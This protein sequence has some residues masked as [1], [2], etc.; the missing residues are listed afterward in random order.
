MDD[1][2]MSKRWK[3]IDD[4]RQ[5]SI[6]DLIRQS[7]GKKLNVAGSMQ[8][9][10]ELQRAIDNAIRRSPLSRHQ[11]AGEMSHLL[12]EE[13]SKAMIDSWTA[14]SKSDRHIPAEYLP[15]FCRV[16]GNQEPIEV[17]NQ[18]AD[19]IALQ[20]PEALRSEIHQMRE[21]ATRVQQEIR[22]REQL[23]KIYRETD[24]KDSD[25]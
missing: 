24:K 20:G 22:K 21:E 15:A 25:R 1:M 13:I 23:L 17:L 4:P 6:Y 2:S 8:C 19:L 3:R 7:Q 12:D 5:R 10:D 16:T 18:K 11:I 14:E 9:K